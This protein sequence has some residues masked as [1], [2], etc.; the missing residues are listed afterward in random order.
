M[1]GGIDGILYVYLARPRRQP[2]C[3]VSELERRQV[4]LEL[5]LARERLQPQRSRRLSLKLASFQARYLAGLVFLKVLY[6]TTEHFAR[7]I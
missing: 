1:G 6:P 4:E 7:F 3:A 5:Q 2:E